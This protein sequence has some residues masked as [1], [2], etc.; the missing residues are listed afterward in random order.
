ME[1]GKIIMGL[2]T[3]VNQPIFGYGIRKNSSLRL[4]LILLFYMDAKFGDT[5]SLEN[6]GERS[7][8]S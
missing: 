3:I 2:K 6:R 4:L 7:R 8:K 5:V 1:D